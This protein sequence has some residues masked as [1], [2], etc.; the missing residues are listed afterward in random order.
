MSCIAHFEELRM[1]VLMQLNDRTY[2]TFTNAVEQWKK[3]YKEPERSMCRLLVL[4][5]LLSPLRKV[6]LYTNAAI[7]GLSTKAGFRRLSVNIVR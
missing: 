4:L 1:D 6:L 7:P 5:S 3:L 2:Q